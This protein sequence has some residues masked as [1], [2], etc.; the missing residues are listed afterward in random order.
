MNVPHDSVQIIR[1]ERFSAQRGMKNITSRHLGTR[2]EI[3]Q[4]GRKVSRDYA[5]RAAAATK[6]NTENPSSPPIV[7]ALAAPV[8]HH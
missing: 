3:L 8:A 5:A 4:P 1:S 6:K 7:A 2:T